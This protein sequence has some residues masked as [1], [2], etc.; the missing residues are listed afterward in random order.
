M[1]NVREAL[2][3]IRSIRGQMARSSEF[4]GYG[5]MTLASTGTL[6][7]L[8]ASIQKLWAVDLEHEPARFLAMWI[9]A[10]AVSLTFISIETIARARR[11]HSTLALQM[12]HAA[13]E[14]FL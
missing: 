7:I 2:S 6:A 8:I 3:Q 4:R 11:I 1:P 10:A 5:P 13:L 9:G 12:L 14:Q